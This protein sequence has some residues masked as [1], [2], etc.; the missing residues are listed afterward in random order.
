MV[1]KT[2]SD[3]EAIL[4]GWNTMKRNIGFFIGILIVAGLIYLVPG[5]FDEF[6]KGKL[7]A[8]LAIIL[9]VTFWVLQLVVGLGLIRI[10]LKFYDNKIPKFGDLFAC[11]PLFFRYLIGSILYT[12]II[13]GGTILFVIPGV[14]WSIKFQFFSYLIVDRGMGPVES[15]KK[16]ASVTQGA[17]WELLAFSFL[18]VIINVLGFLSLLIGLFATIPT[19]MLAYAFVYRQLLLQTETNQAPQAI[20]A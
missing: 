2:F 20:K 5:V 8:F 17:K 7:P 6:L 1:T 18:L 9:G 13:I 10:A 12:L 4:F 19:V 16:S 11:F 15:L 3:G 14:I